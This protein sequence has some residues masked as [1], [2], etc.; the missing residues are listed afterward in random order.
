MVG[1]SDNIVR[2][3]VLS[4]RSEMNTLMVF[5]ALVGGLQAFGFIGLFAGPVIFSVALVV[6][7]MLR[8][9]YSGERPSE[10]GAE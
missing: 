6:F 9:E 1:L 7:R 4:G 8:E 3:L 5:F 2:P 10:G